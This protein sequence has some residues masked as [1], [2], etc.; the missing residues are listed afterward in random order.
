MDEIIDYGKWTVP[1]RWEDVTLKQFQEI[2]RYYEDK[3]KKFDVREVL[4]IFTN[5]TRDEIN[6]LPIEFLE[7]IMTHLLFLQA[8][9]ES[10]ESRNWVMIDGVRYSVHTENKLKTGEYIA[11]DT[12]LKE[13][14]HNYATLLAILCRK[15]GELYDSKFENEVI[16]GR[17]K[18]WEKVPVVEVLPIIGFFLHLYVAST[19]PTLLSSQI[20][21]AVN[22]TRKDIETSHKNGEISKRSMRSAMR[23]LRKLEKSISTISATTSNS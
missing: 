5:H 23:K 11:A 19:T 6:A 14:S 3:D 20:M 8:P 13:D 16:E 4:E 2:E 22:L 10:K 1:T 21:E 17:I 12:V 18:M 7:E 9:I 15:E